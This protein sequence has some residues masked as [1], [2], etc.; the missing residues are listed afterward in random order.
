VQIAKIENGVVVSVGD[1]ASLFPT[2]SFADTGPDAE[3]LQEFSCKVVNNSL[4]YNSLTH[5]LI[6][7]PAYIDGDIVRTVEVAELTTEE[8]EART[9]QA[10]GN[11]RTTRNTM[12]RA[13]D[14]TQIGDVPLNSDQ[15]R[16]WSEYRQ[17]LRDV[18]TQQDPMNIVWPIAPGQDAD[19]LKAPASN[20]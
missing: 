20:Q 6:E 14:W 15:R 12:L 9:V 7:A 1:A 10:W 16:A 2:T 11:V 5:K 19:A 3:F 4:P 13:C 18:T 8:V 17:A